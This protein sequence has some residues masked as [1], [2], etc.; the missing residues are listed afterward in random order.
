[1]E[2]DPDHDHYIAL[3]LVDNGQVTEEAIE[4]AYYRTMERWHP[5]R[6]PNSPVAEKRARD[7]NVAWSVLGDR[8]ER[9]QY[10]Q[11]KSEALAKV[12][13]LS[14]DAPN[15]WLE[16]IRQPVS[17]VVAVVPAAARKAGSVA[18]KVAKVSAVIGVSGF[19][20]AGAAA[21]VHWL[22]KKRAERAAGAGR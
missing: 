15:T 18:L 3:D 20:V 12:P 1:M 21:G 11:A 22:L 5:D 16:L 8:D 6:N 2:Y 9:V 10:D 13:R 7:A 14:D 19:V 17:R 4:A